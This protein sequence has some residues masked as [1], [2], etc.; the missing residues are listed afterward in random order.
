MGL[1]IQDYDDLHM[2]MQLRREAQARGSN[3]FEWQ[4]QYY[5]VMLAG[6]MINDHLFGR[7][8]DGVEEQRVYN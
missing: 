3:T 7:G 1:V 6:D 4:G 8:K 2:F 5:H